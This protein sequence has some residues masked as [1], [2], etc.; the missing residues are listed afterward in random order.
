[1]GPFLT[2][3][4]AIV[5]EKKVK[6]SDG[7]WAQVQD[8]FSPDNQENM[9]AEDYMKHK[10]LQALFD[11]R[12]VVWNARRRRYN[13]AFDAI[14]GQWFD[15]ETRRW[16]MYRHCAERENDGSHRRLDIDDFAD[17]ASANGINLDVPHV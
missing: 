16:C 17:D 14:D 15:R 10:M 3:R 13:G 8:L 12:R 1:M 9:K 4:E 11:D 5:Y 2:R 7:T 6:E